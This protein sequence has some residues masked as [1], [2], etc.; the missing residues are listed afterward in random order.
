MGISLPGRKF[1]TFI[2]SEPVFTSLPLTAAIR[3]A[4]QMPPVGEITKKTDDDS[5]SNRRPIELIDSPRCQRSQIS[6]LR[7]AE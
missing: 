7:A 1:T 3:S 6:A 4:G 2:K 5:R